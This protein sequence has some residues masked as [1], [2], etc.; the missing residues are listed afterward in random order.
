M[1]GSPRIG[2]GAPWGS[3]R[4]EHVTGLLVLLSTGIALTVGFLC[5]LATL[6]RDEVDRD[7]QVDEWTRKATLLETEEEAEERQDG[8]FLELLE[9]LGATANDETDREREL[10]LCRDEI[11][12]L[13]SQLQ[14]L[15]PLGELL[16][17]TEI[18]L[19]QARAQA[20]EIEARRLR[21]ANRLK[22]LQARWRAV[23]ADAAEAA[24][25]IADLE[26]RLARF[27][28]DKR[29]LASQLR[30]IERNSEP[31]RLRAER[32]E[33]ALERSLAR[34]RK[35]QER[36]LAAHRKLAERPVASAW[37]K[38]PVPQGVELGRVDDAAAP[39]SAASLMRLEAAEIDAA[40]RSA[41]VPASR[42]AQA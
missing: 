41:P 16:G 6:R 10:A 19:Q 23:P 15:V 18:E 35:R 25:R 17:Q 5:G 8:E 42:A 21:A 9:E 11:E 34:S 37:P 20:E 2:D 7:S 31:D 28:S 14:D 1:E 27:K 36:L 38:S 13:R 22:K 39:T 26:G 29:R 4:G 32:V 12:Q 30:K 33:E 24:T 3:N 40:Q